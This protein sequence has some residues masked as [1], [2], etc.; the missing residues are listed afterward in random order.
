LALVG[1]VA[2]QFRV[3]VYQQLR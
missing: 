3:A 2:F 1:K